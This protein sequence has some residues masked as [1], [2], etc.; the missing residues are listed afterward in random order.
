VEAVVVEPVRVVAVVVVAAVV[1]VQVVR[2]AAPV[3]RKV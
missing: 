3:S 1:P 2:E